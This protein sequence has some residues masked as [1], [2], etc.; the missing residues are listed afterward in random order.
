MVQIIRDSGPGE[1]FGTGLSAALNALA[2][3]KFQQV[4]QQHDTQRQQAARQ[5]GLAALFGPEQAKALSSL[6][7]SLLKPIIQEKARGQRQQ[8]VTGEGIKTIAPLLD[9]EKAAKVATLSP[10]LQQIW[11]RNYLENPQ[12]AIQ[13]LDNIKEPVR[14]EKELQELPAISENLEAIR[15]KIEPENKPA[16]SPFDNK[17]SPKEEV[18]EIRN[19]INKQQPKNITDYMKEGLGRKEAFEQTKADR[20]EN[21]VAEKESLKTYQ[22][23]E[24]AKTA[25]K[26]NNERLDRMR[27]LIE[28]GNLPV[29]LF[30]KTI[31]D[32]SDANFKSHIPLIGPF[33]DLIINGVIRNMG[34][35]AEYAQKGFFAPDTEEFEK[36]TQDFT[37]DAKEVYGAR[38]TNMELDQFMKMIPSLLQTNRGKEAVIR[39]MRN[40]NKAVLARANA[41]ERIIKANGGKRPPNLEILIDEVAKTEL[42]KL[43]DEYVKGIDENSRRSESIYS[44]FNV[45]EDYNFAES[46]LRRLRK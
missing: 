12:Q 16:I 20:K 13:S 2:Q 21:A 4:Q 39:N 44:Q 24:K 27:K 31:K 38:V 5:S 35:V 22:E 40:F 46:L 28:K 8:L 41:M 45:P 43:A 14:S 29:A 6:D 36:L 7:E 19:L 30:Y 34:S 37:R 32:A 3:S 11:Y 17:L 33:A 18:K 9:D 25:A 26:K 42:D 23:L 15:N 10:G 1:K